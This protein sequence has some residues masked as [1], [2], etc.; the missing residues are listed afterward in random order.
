MILVTGGA[1]FIGSNVVKSLCDSGSDVAV[2]DHLGSEGKWKNLRDS[3]IWKFWQP[4][5]ITRA[6]AGGPT[7]VI[8]LGAISDTT[9]TNADEVMK[10]N[11]T[12]SYHI[13]EWCSQHK[14][15]FIYASS[16]ATYGD[17]S[18]G[19]DDTCD[20]STFKP[21]N[22][23][24]WSKHLFDQKVTKCVQTSRAAPPQWVGLKFFNVY[25][26]KETH[27][28][29]MASV[30]FNQYQALKRGESLRL[31]KS[32]VSNLA[33]GEQSRDFVWVGDVVKVIRWFLEHPEQSGLFNVGTGTA[34]SFN[35]V[36]YALL[37]NLG[38]PRHIDYVDMPEI[39]RDKYQNFTEA[40]MRKLRDAGF[41]DSMCSVED[42]VAQY[43]EWLKENLP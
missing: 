39:L 34:R 5:E 1:G 33:D 3:N 11:F 14:V 9:A 15:P 43:V 10:T 22:L 27:K 40:K 13:W 36:A 29:R 31:F 24:G 4:D 37:E 6:L 25:G 8:H 28:D 26:P 7:A 41:T 19:F 17:G 12:L 21:L 32:T 20:L 38:L 16:A 2:V 30:C 42:G 35:S 23:Y 18:A